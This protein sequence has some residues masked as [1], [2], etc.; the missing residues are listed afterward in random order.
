MPPYWRQLRFSVAVYITFLKITCHFVKHPRLGADIQSLSTTYF[1]SVYTGNRTDDGS[2]VESEPDLPLKRKQRRSRTTFTA[3]QLEELEKAFERTHYPDIYTREEL[4][5]R[6]K[7]TEA[8]VQV[9]YA[10]SHRYLYFLCMV[11]QLQVTLNVS[12]WLLELLLELYL[13]LSSRCLC[14]LLVFVIFIYSAETNCLTSPPLR[15]Y[16]TLGQ[17]TVGT[18]PYCF[19]PESS[20]RFLTVCEPCS[21]M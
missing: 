10:H 18:L 2:D 5:Q 21:F 1:Q 8:R 19:H 13:L 12:D 7:L 11:S 14:L 6:T 9:G 17:M 15:E 4:A 16:I 20:G 3:E